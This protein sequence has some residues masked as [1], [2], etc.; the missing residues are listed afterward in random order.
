MKEIKTKECNK[1]PKLKNPASRMPKELIRDALLK[2]REN[3]QEISKAYDSNGGRESPVEYADRKT[4]AAEGRVADA[5]VRA[6]STAGRMMAK[7]SYEKMRKA[8]PGILPRGMK[9]PQRIAS[10]KKSGKRRSGRK[11]IFVWNRDHK[12][13]SRQTE[14]KQK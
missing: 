2:V 7:K 11:R 13:D 12:P 10:K 5:S 4:E 6:V 14:S 3:H 1:A 8:V 9:I